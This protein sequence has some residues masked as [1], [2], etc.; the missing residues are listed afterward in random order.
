MRVMLGEDGED[1]ATAPEIA[2]VIDV[3][4]HLLGAD[5]LG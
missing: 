5:P 4:I 3:E 1:T 2:K